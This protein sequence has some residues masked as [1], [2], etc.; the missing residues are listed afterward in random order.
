MVR[1]WPKYDHFLAYFCPLI[2]L[3]LPTLYMK[4][5]E[6]THEEQV[7]RVLKEMVEAGEMLVEERDGELYFALQESLPTSTMEPYEL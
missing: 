2:G 3:N 7:F 5:T 1:K 6:E 4:H